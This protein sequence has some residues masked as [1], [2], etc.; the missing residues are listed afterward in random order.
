[1]IYQNHPR[2]CFNQLIG[3]IQSVNLDYRYHFGLW[4]LSEVLR[5]LVES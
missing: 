2:N 3:F 1:M 5:N 4:D